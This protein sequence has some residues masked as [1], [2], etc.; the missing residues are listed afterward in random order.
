MSIIGQQI[1]AAKR[2]NQEHISA[3]EAAKRTGIPVEEICRWCR[4]GK[5][6]DAVKFDGDQGQEWAIYPKG[7]AWI[8][9]Y[10]AARKIAQEFLS[11]S[12][13]ES[14]NA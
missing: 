5:V 4:Q 2:R 14:P 9:D 13:K 7:Y 1:A 8:V 6:P 3:R 10:D 11:M 12:T